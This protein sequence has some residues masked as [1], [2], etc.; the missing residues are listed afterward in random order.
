MVVHLLLL[1]LIL[2]II[3]DHSCNFRLLHPDELISSVVDLVGKVVVAVESTTSIFK[4]AGWSARVK[5]M[6]WLATCGD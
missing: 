1:L 5:L 6:R 4:Q 3:T 2:L